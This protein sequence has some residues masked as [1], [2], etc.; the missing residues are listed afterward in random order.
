MRLF[1]RTVAWHTQYMPKLKKC[2]LPFLFSGKIGYNW[3]M[4]SM[5]IRLPD[6]LMD[7]LTRQAKEQHRTKNKQ[8]EFI[9]SQAAAQDVAFQREKLIS[10]LV[11]NDK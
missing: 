7:W 2:Q 9:V 5:T 10:L 1:F 11:E 4:Q 6:E 8:L 3:G